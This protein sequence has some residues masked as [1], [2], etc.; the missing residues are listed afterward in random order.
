MPRLLEEQ[1]LANRH[2]IRDV[3]VTIL[4]VPEI[5]QIAK[6]LYALPTPHTL[7]GIENAKGRHPSSITLVGLPLPRRP[8]RRYHLITRTR[9]L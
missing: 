9:L 4:P 1:Q 6:S 2:Q 8:D 3:G 7:K 5:P